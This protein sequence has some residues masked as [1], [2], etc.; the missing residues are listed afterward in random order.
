MRQTGF[1]IACAA[2]AALA[3]FGVQGCKYST[4]AAPLPGPSLAPTLPPGVVTEA[5]IPTANATPLGI[6]KAPDGN[7]WF[8]E[9]NGNNIARVIPST[10]VITEFPIPTAGAGPADVTAVTGHP[11]VWFD[12]FAGN[13]IASVVPSTGV[14]T[15]IPIPTSGA[16]PVGLTSDQSG[17]LWFAEFQAGHPKITS[18][19]VGGSFSENPIPIANSRPD[20]VV[21][22]N[23]NTVWFLDAGTNSV[24]HLTFSGGNPTFTEFAIP[25]AGSNPQSIVVGPDGNLWFTEIGPIP[26]SGCKIGKVTL[27]ATPS[28]TEYPLSLPQPAPDGAFCIGITSAGGFLWFGE[29]N[30]GQIGRITTGGVVTEYGIPGAGTTAVDVALGPDGDVWFTDGGI[31]PNVTG[32]GTNQVGKVNIG[33]IPMASVRKTYQARAVKSWTR[34]LIVHGIRVKPR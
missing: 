29:A 2:A 14:V 22:A 16:Q 13:K 11:N 34:P 24:G 26:T 6:A 19:T 27:G 23:D 3:A 10:M 30:S 31:D 8:A 33:Q 15:E 21:I 18:M 7:V 17:V 32:I 12:E 25:T 5:A 4:N 28:I 9:L 1:I 20:S